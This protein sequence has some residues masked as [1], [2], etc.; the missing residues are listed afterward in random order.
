MSAGR[1]SA[2]LSIRLR[3]LLSSIRIPVKIRNGRM[4]RV[5]DFYETILDDYYNVA[6]DVI[7]D[8]KDRP[9]KAA[10]V[11]SGIVTAAVAY[12]TNPDE[13]CFTDQIISYVHDMG[14]VDPS[15][16]HKPAY[17]HVHEMYTIWNQRRM[18]RL[19]LIFFSL[20]WQD[21]HTP[22]SGHYLSQCSY[23]KPSIASFFRDRVVDIGAFGRWRMLDHKLID[24]DVNPSEWMSG[25]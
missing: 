21:D 10:I 13:R 1:S 7:R 8:A 16:R 24:Y 19:N 2:S 5:F 20:M 18:R 17:D 25:K 23:L 4:K 15:V 22:D 11:T 6:K 3:V 9:I 12:K 14:M